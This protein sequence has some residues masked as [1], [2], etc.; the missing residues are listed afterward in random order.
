M[1]LETYW[2]GKQ[3]VM[4]ADGYHTLPVMFLTWAD[5]SLVHIFPARKGTIMKHLALHLLLCLL[6]FSAGVGIE[7]ILI[8]KA[9]PPAAAPLDTPMLFE[10]LA[11]TSAF[12][13]QPASTPSP[14]PLP[15]SNLILDYDV[16]KFDPYGSYVLIGNKPARISEFNG[17]SL[18][19][20]ATEE[21]ETGGD[22]FVWTTNRESAIDEHKAFGLLTEKRLILATTPTED[23]IVYRFE[24][25]FLRGK[26]IAE[27]PEGRAV[28]TGTLTKS[29]KG[30]KIA[31]SVIKLSVEVD[32]C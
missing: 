19:L 27:A 5:T 9:Q 32:H 7:R 6:T 26:V 18:D 13:V 29:K 30:R 11:P 1:P 28:L 16:T 14:T 2:C 23:G 21:G 24:G 25:E 12:L 4:A 31:E 3:Y 8:P 17:F 15:A 20:F 22:I 10:P